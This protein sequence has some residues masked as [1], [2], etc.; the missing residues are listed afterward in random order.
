[1]DTDLANP[2]RTVPYAKTALAVLLAVLDGL[3]PVFSGVPARNDPPAGLPRVPPALSLPEVVKGAVGP[4]PAHSDGYGNPGASG[5]GYI[6]LITLHTGQTRRE[7]AITG[8]TG[9]GLDGTLA[10]DRAEA[11][12]AYLGQIN[13]IV[14]SSFVGVNGAIWGYDVAK[15]AE[16]GER[17]LF[18]IGE[19]KTGGIPVYPADPLLDA[20]A[21]LL[22]TRDAPRF[23]LLPGA[24]V[25]A[26]HK[27]ITAPGPATVWCG[28]A[29]AIAAHRATDASAI[30]EL[31][32]KHRGRSGRNPP[33]E[34]YFRLIRRNLAKSVLRVGANQGVRYREIFVVVKHE[35]VPPGSI[36]H[37]MATAP[38][39]VLANNA[40]PPGGPE[41]LLEM[42]IYDWERTVQERP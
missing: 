16:I 21:R 41:K 36:G 7:L 8:Q 34:H 40:V 35:F 42:G 20:A 12:G 24:Q 2:A 26:A 6:T 37:A 15:A 9:E 18:E 10:F 30:M 22:G 3:T 14:A 1:M 4:F 13:L 28:V 32:G 29:I 39:I 17:K 25:I 31:C 27:E 33:G 38:Y 11:N 19:P 23:P 5:L